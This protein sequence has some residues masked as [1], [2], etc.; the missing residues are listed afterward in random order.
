MVAWAWMPFVLAVKVP[1]A[2]STNSSVADLV[3]LSERVP[4]TWGKL[5]LSGAAAPP[6]GS[7]RQLK[8]PVYVP[9]LHA[10]VPSPVHWFVATPPSPRSEPEPAPSCDPSSEAPGAS[11]PALSSTPASTAGVDG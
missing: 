7:K 10:P 9:S 8:L 11:E 4:A 3:S 2:T 1:L 5:L 6:S